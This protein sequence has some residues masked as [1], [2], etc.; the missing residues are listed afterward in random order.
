MTWIVMAY[1]DGVW[2]GVAASPRRMSTE[3]RLE[4]KWLHALMCDMGS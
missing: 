3:T 1:M 4:M 2:G